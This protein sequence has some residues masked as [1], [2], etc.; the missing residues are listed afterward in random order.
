MLART[1]ENHQYLIRFALSNN[2]RFFRPLSHDLK[3][4]LIESQKGMVGGRVL[5][6]AVEDADTPSRDPCASICGV[7][8]RSFCG[9]GITLEIIRQIGTVEM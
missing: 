2:S 6:W 8:S 9:R 3:E 4:D 5:G 1:P 7:S